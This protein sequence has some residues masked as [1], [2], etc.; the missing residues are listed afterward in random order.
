LTRAILARERLATA[1]DDTA[2]HIKRKADRWVA[3]LMQQQGSELFILSAEIDWVLGANV[4]GSAEAAADW[5]VITRAIPDAEH[6][7]RSP[8][9]ELVVVVL[10][11]VVRVYAARD[12][13]P[14]T[15]L[16]EYT[17]A[18]VVMVQWA[19]ARTAARWDTLFAAVW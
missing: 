12:G 5:A 1:A 6:V 3:E 19:D 13:S 4:L 17:N 8:G 10:P 7:F 2:W 9:G 11:G 18:D 16:A 15:S 14:T